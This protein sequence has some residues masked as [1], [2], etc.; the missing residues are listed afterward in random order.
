VTK[1]RWPSWAILGWLAVGIGVAVLLTSTTDSSS[2]GYRFGQFMWI[3]LIGFVALGVAW[4][5]RRP[6]YTCRWCGLSMMNAGTRCPRCGFYEG[7]PGV[8]ECPSCR[9][10]VDMRVPQCPRCGFFPGSGPGP[11]VP[12]PA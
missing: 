12:P 8:T 10:L 2:A 3:W 7:M 1:W 5:Q 11:Q 6:G 9:G 4:R